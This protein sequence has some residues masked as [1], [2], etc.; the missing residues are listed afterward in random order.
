MIRKLLIKDLKIFFSDK[1]A[2]MI[3]V[4]MPIILM[5]ILGIAIGGMMNK[6]INP[7]K[8]ALVKKY[9]KEDLDFKTIFNTDKKTIDSFGTVFSNVIDGEKIFFNDFLDKDEVKKWINY[10]IMD[11]NKAKK[12]Y[13]KGKIDG[14]L[15]LDEEFYRGLS[16]SLMGYYEKPIKLILYSDKDFIKSRLVEEILYEFSDSVSYVGIANKIS[17]KKL[18][19]EKKY[20]EISNELKK[21]AEKITKIKIEISEKNLSESKKSIN[22]ISY[23]AIGMMAMF[24]LYGVTASSKTLLKEKENGTLGRNVIAGISYWDIIFSKYIFAVLISLYQ[25]FIMIIYGKLVLKV[26]YGNTGLLLLTL[27]ISSLS[28][29]AISLF[30]LVITIKSNSFNLVTTIETVFIQILALLGGSMI[31]I[32]SFPKFMQKISDYIINGVF[33]KTLLKISGGSE[34]LEI[35]FNLF[36]ITSN[37]IIFLVLALLSLK[38][39]E[40]FDVNAKRKI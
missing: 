26:E 24:M 38:T 8:I 18:L 1:K 37:G 7:A 34:F 35:K 21:N 17:L 40:V 13:E 27:I 15:I 28:L 16:M 25:F 31:P 2:S 12:L 29:G 5:T 33:I 36:V 32:E 6:E 10:E 3:L 9:K 20:N 4:L 19:K 22:G 39:M 11:E 23:Y 30:L 14:I